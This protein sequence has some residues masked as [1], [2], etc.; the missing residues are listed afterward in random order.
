MLQMLFGL[1]LLF[2]SL[3][4]RRQLFTSFYE[5]W[6]RKEMSFFCLTKK[7]AKRKKKMEARDLVFFGDF[8]VSDVLL[9]V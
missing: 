6:L 4:G 5:K 1:S 3:D 7:E 9:A 8:F 2:W